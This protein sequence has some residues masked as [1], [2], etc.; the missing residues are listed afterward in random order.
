MI[1]VVESMSIVI[2][3][4]GGS[5]REAASVIRAIATSGAEDRRLIGYLDEAKFARTRATKLAAPLLGSPIDVELL[6][7]LPRPCAFTIAI[8]NGSVRNRL[9]KDLLASGMT[10]A[11]LIH[12]AA[13]IGACRVSPW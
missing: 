2:V 13:V 6:A 1:V 7:A 4:T 5:G 3:G 11:V 8:G 10:E 12:P 9:R